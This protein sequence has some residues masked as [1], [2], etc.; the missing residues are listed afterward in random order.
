MAKIKNKLNYLLALLATTF[1]GSALTQDAP[2]AAGSEEEAAK[3]AS[4][5][6]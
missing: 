5:V 3:E 4:V 1:S 2:E 6:L